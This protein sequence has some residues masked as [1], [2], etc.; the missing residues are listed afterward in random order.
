[1]HIRSTRAEAHTTYTAKPRALSSTSIATSSADTRIWV[2]GPPASKTLGLLA[3][4]RVPQTPRSSRVAVGETPLQRCMT[5]A[6]LAPNPEV[7][8]AGSVGRILHAVHCRSR[9]AGTAPPGIRAYGLGCQPHPRFGR[10]KQRKRLPCEL[11]PERKC[12]I[13]RSLEIT[14]AV[15]NTP[16]SAASQR[17]GSTA[18]EASSIARHEARGI[19]PRG[20][21]HTREPAATF[22]PN[23]GDVRRLR[24]TRTCVNIQKMPHPNTAARARAGSFGHSQS[25]N[26]KIQKFDGRTRSASSWNSLRRVCTYHE[27]C[28]LDPSNPR[29]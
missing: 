19:L 1:M 15:P 2:L 28:F 18:Q 13:K 9:H 29:Y 24:P 11:S 23:N 4:N 8:R 12:G 14:G 20:S 10:R 5:F 27:P 16:P 17:S 22:D 6:L 7:E 25:G 3:E 26:S 21:A